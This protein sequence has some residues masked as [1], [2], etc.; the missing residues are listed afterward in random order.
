MVCTTRSV[1]SVRGDSGYERSGSDRSRG[2]KKQKKGSRL[3]DS[4]FPKSAIGRADQR[5]L[6]EDASDG[7]AQPAGSAA[8]A[9]SA[10]AAGAVKA[11]VQNAV[12]RRDVRPRELRGVD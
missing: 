10:D 1:Y 8:E 4:P 2:D 3:R 5:L 6:A 12:R 11:A 7:T 9:R